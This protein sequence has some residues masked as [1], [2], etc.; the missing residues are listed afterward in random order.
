MV[1]WVDKT[2]FVQFF[3]V[4]LPPLLNLFCFCLVLT[5]SFLYH[6]HP[7][8]KYSL[9]I[10]N[11]LE[12]ISSLLHS[13]GLLFHCIVR[14]EAFLISHCF[15]LKLCIQMDISFSFSLAFHFS[16]FFS[17]LENLLRQSLCLLAFIFIW[18]GFAHH[19]L[20]NVMNI[21]PQIFRHSV[22]QI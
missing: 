18:D 9:G 10:S 13:I 21:C 15:S 7:C 8:T 12:E 16:S 2:T 5:I 20:Y 6:A 22:Y 1:I 19:V 3:S 4:F 14:L 17:C 11:F